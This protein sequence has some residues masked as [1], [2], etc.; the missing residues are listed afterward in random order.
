MI[1]IQATIYVL[2]TNH[3]LLFGLILSLFC[4]FIRICAYSMQASAPASVLVD[5]LCLRTQLCFTHNMTDI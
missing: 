5:S 2:Y 3:L 4:P 1:L